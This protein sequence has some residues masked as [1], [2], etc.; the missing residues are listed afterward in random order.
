MFCY[1]NM[2]FITLMDI[3]SWIRYHLKIKRSVAHFI[4][5]V[6]STH[7]TKLTSGLFFILFSLM[8]GIVLND[9][10]ILH[11]HDI[12]CGY[13]RTHKYILLMCWWIVVAKQVQQKKVQV[14]ECIL[15]FYYGAIVFRLQLFNRG[16]YGKGNHLKTIRDESICLKEIIVIVTCL[17]RTIERIKSQ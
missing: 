10:S 11:P 14:C 8:Y 16:I 12:V 9:P 5:L 6:P 17:S 15:Y 1:Y 7:V 13:E 2:S 3:F 4:F